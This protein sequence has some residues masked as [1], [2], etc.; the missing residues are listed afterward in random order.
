[1]IKNIPNK[2]TSEML[3]EL[4]DSRLADSYDFLYLPIDLNVRKC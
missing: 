4:I 3:V 1:M 2:Y